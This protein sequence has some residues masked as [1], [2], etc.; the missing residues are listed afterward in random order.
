LHCK[1]GGYWD[2]MIPA[3]VGCQVF[4]ILGNSMSTRVLNNNTKH[5]HDYSLDELIKFMD[6]GVKAA[7]KAVLTVNRPINLL[8][9]A[10][11]NAKQNCI[12]I[13]WNSVYAEKANQELITQF[14]R[15]S[16]AVNNFV[17]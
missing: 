5:N 3:L 10:M 4:L 8:D 7:Q 11:G 12:A 15:K 1:D 2:I 13:G 9:E 6:A 14:N 16:K 17:A